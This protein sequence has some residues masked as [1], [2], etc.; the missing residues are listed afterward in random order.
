MN[1]TQWLISANIV[2][3]LILASLY[4]RSHRPQPFVKSPKM[5]AFDRSIGLSKEESQTI[6]V[7][8]IDEVIA[9]ADRTVAEMPRASSK[10][11]WDW[12]LRLVDIQLRLSMNRSVTREQNRRMATIARRLIGQAQAAGQDK[13]TMNGLDWLRAVGTSADLDA[14]NPAL[15]SSNPSVARVAKRTAD[16]LT[17]VSP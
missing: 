2:I 1:R 16:R 9:I 8:P 14:V 6:D 4:W 5:A 13:I 11:D 7:G 12:A 17:R 15:A 10:I 3:A